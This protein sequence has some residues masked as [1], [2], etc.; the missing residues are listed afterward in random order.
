MRADSRHRNA[1]IDLSEIVGRTPRRPLR[2]GTP[3]RRSDVRA[4]IVVAKDSIVTLELRT[5]RMTLSAKVKATQD[6]AKGQTI[7]LLNTRS[8][9]VI[10]GVVVGPRRVVVPRPDL[11][12]SGSRG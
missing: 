8:K 5:G 7:R 2:A 3:I 9:R 10:E 4:P 12:T 1:V 6:G 11:P